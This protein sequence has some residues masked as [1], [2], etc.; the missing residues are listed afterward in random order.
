MSDKIINR[1][2]QAVVAV[3]VLSQIEAIERF[4]RPVMYV[5]WILLLLLSL[6]QEIRSFK[7]SRGTWFYLRSYIAFALYCIVCSLFSGDAHLNGNY[8]RTMMIPL[9]VMII[10]DSC[11]KRINN[12][13]LLNILKTY[14]VFSVVLAIYINFTYFNS[15]NSWLSLQQYVYMD[16]NSAAQ[17]WGTAVILCFYIIKYDNR[18]KLLWWIAAIYILIVCGLSQCRTAI[19]G[20]LLCLFVYVVGYQ[21]RYKF[22]F[23]VIAI[24]GFAV[25]LT[26]SVS[27]EFINQA[28]RLNRFSSFD[29]NSITSDRIIAINRALEYV[30]QHLF[31]GTGSYYVDCSYISILA[32]SGIIGFVIIESVWI[33]RIYVNIRFS[34]EGRYGTFNVI[35]V[36]FTI[37]YIIESVFEGYPPFGPGVSSF[38]FWFLCEQSTRDYSREGF[39]NDT[40]IT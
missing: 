24:V 9:L 40:A 8:L 17:I 4:A 20:L 39:Q 11:S 18:P 2:F 12:R 28:L 31:I 3:S 26:N 15:Y 27:R 34:K 5:S 19:L 25:L 13:G 14:I 37:L 30:D 21:R 36:M 7:L 22:I 35:I 16:K 38:M 6:T 10:T 23:V 32:E 1:Y 29:L 33:N